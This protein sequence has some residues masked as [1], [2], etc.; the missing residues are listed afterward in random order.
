MDFIQDPTAIETKSMAIID[1][2][3][4]PLAVT[5]EERNVIK[6]IVHT[7]GDPG[8][9]ELVHLHPDAVPNGIAALARGAKIFTDVHM[10]ATGIK[11][12]LVEERGG[13]I[14]CAIRD[15]RV[16][17]AAKASGRTR[18]MTA[19]ELLAP[20][21]DG[22]VV[23]IG[24]APTALFQLLDA[25]KKGICLPACV[26]GTPV[27]FVGAAES[28]ECL[29]EAGIPAISIRGTKGGSTIAVAIINALLL[30]MPK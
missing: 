15:S 13:D 14:I 9:A 4:G 5:A 12:N 30:Q 11:R 26:V 21:M 28:K 22:A 20:E 24:N 23:A 7:T 27:G 16:I 8:F 18:A 10:L 29:I 2:L 19:F 3:L 6:R 25:I 17:E 1:E